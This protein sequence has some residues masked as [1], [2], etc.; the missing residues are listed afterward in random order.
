MSEKGLVLID[1]NNLSYRVFW[2]H[3]QLRHKA[4]NVGLL[5]GFL[6]S[7]IALRKDYKQE[8]FVVAWDWG[9]ERRK[10]ESEAGV[11]A[12]IIPSAYKQNR[13]D[14]EAPPE[15]ELMFEQMDTLRDDFLPLTNVVQSHKKGFEADDI[16]FTYV[17]QYAVLR[18]VVVITSDKDFY[19][20]LRPN[21][22]I[23]NPAADKKTRFTA[24]DFETEYGFEPRLWVDVGALEGD[25]GDNIHG[26]PKWG[27]KTA[28]KYIQ[29]HGSVEAVIEAVRAK[30]KRGKIEDALLEHLDRVDLARSLKQMDIVPELPG[31]VG[32][33]GDEDALRQ[34]CIE[35]SFVS[36]LK[37]L[38][39]LV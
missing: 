4:M 24:D 37:D 19:Q 25:S 33:A 21:V 22:T 35:K 9:S 14:R 34:L 13:K 32:E 16:I 5:Y 2:T 1:G 10:R 17:H 8:D 31:V 20:L 26:V 7:L 36:L 15:F 23:Y 28:C 6:R 12:G 38:W 27:V 39:R 18:P 30:Q 3:R 11:E 29:Q